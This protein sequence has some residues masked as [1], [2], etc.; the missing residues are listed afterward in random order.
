MAD[1]VVVDPITPPVEGPGQTLLG[2]GADSLPAGTDTQALAEGGDTLTGG[3]GNDSISGKEGEGTQ[4]APEGAPERYELTFAEGVT[5]DPAAQTEF[6][7]FARTNNL[8]NEAAQTA[9]TLFTKQLEA[10]ATAFAEAQTTQ[11]KTV[12]ETWRA[13]LAKDPQFQGDNLKEALVTIGRSIDTYGTPEVRAALDMT[14]AG[15]NPALVR[16]IH[17]MAAALNE[18]GLI[19]AGAPAKSGPRSLGETFYPDSAAQG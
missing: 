13:D 11:W 17:K 14:G 16:Y 2:T 6:E 8:T 18:G 3:E 4:P 15:N 9:V 10:Q 7:D 5:V 19:T 12:N 1:E